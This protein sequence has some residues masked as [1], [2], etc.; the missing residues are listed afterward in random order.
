MDKQRMVGLDRLH[1]HISENRKVERAK[2]KENGWVV[3]K[4]F[5]QPLH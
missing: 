1:S 3:F 2:A 4:N 5:Y